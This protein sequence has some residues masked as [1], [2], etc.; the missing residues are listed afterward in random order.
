MARPP[1]RYGDRLRKRG[2]ALIDEP[3]DQARGHRT[4]FFRDP[5]GN[6]LGVYADL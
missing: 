4:C 3:T 1:G 2:I 6:V 5:A